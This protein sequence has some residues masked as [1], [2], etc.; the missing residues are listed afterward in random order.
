MKRL[1][2]LR[3]A[4]GLT[5]VELSAIMNI[6]KETISRYESE[7]LYGN[8]DKLI[9]FAEFYGTTID[10]LLERTNFPY[11]PTFFIEEP[12]KA[13][14]CL[15]DLS[16][17]NGSLELLEKYLPPVKNPALLKALKKKKDIDKAVIAPHM[18]NEEISKLSKKDQKKVMRLIAELKSG[19]Y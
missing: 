10:F 12:Q 13:Q 14:E 17:W 9:I 18:L 8:Y 1:L 16:D 4:Y 2:L 11:P 3:K 19:T 5:R 15:V 7:E 6:H